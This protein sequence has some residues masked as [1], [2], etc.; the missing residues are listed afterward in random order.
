MKPQFIIMSIDLAEKSTEKPFI[1]GV[2][3]SRSLKSYPKTGENGFVNTSLLSGVFE[4]VYASIS[5][6]AF[7]QKS[8]RTRS[9]DQYTHQLRLQ[10]PNGDEYMAARIQ[11]LMRARYMIIKLTNGRSLIIGRNDVDQ[12]TRPKITI[13]SNTRTTQVTFE[14]Q[15]IFPAGHFNDLS[16][17]LLPQL[18]PLSIA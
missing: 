16:G 4:D 17:K 12:N 3:Y 6:I 15:S 10:F 5:A 14:C 1:C 11:E 18:I 8:T 2:A 13:E 9:G 7:N